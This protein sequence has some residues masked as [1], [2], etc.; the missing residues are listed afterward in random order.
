MVP[1]HAKLVAARLRSQLLSGPPATEPEE[2][3]RRLLA[4]QAQD[5]TGA[6]LTVRSRSAGLHA[7]DVDAALNSRSLIVTWVNR[8]TLHLIAAED[9]W[10]LHRLTTPQLATQNRR[11]L[12]QEGVTAAQAARGVEVVSEAVATDGPLTRPELAG[13]LDHAGVPTAGQAVIHVL[14]A[15]TLAGRIV[16]GP[17]RGRQH[18][19]VS[20]VDWLGDPTEPRPRAEEL[21]RLARRYLRGHGPAG[22]E[23]LAKWA[24]IT[25]GD[26]RTAMAGVAEEVV[27]F[28]GADRLVTLARGDEEGRKGAALPPPRLH[29]AFDPLLLG[30]ASRSDWIGKHHGLVTTNGIFR[31]FA[32]VGG[33]A[34][35]TWALTTKGLRIRPL[36]PVAQLSL[37]A[38]TVDGN[39]VLRFLARPPHLKVTIEG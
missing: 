1:A 23:D 36:E 19:F 2:V 12:A 18:A 8:G 3:V 4:V 39:D 28:P 17:M 27:P 16:R 29:G 20:V 5:P 26:A 31:P 7:A 34:V 38:L 9:Y 37:D 25:L 6:R 10:W 33:R 13:R 32:L 15:A 11:R 30:W 14:V 24:G 21:A 22:P 35:A